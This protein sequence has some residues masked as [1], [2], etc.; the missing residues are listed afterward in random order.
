MRN[1]VLH[2]EEKNNSFST[3]RCDWLLCL[4]WVLEE[5]SKSASVPRPLVQGEVAPLGH[6]R[7]SNSLTALEHNIL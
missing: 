3:H 2:G 7:R 5:A 1:A 4:G 6:C